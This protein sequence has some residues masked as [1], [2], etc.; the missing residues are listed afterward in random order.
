MKAE[1]KLFVVI[2][3]F[4]TVVGLIY[5]TVTHWKEPVGPFG[6][7]LCAALSALIGFYLWETGRKL[8]PRPE[9][10]PSA[11]I[12]GRRRGIRLLQPS[13]LVAAALGC[14]RRGRLPRPCRRLV[15]VHH[16][17]V[18]GCRGPHRLDVR[19]LSWRARRLIRGAFVAL[20]RSSRAQGVGWDDVR[21]DS[22]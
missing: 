11:L 17:P 12:F 22:S 8:D 1:F 10:D 7:L 16:W 20:A 18:S 9:D 6:L 19:V 4:F 15:A 2:G 13:Q 21:P 5:G 3:T 14:V